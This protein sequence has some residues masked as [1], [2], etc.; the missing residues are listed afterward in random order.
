MS[1]DLPNANDT[2][3]NK[4]HL[5]TVLPEST[6][7]ELLARASAEPASPWFSGHFPGEPILP[8]IAQIQMVLETIQQ[9]EKRDVCIAGL[10]RVRFRQV[11]QP[12]DEIAIRVLPRENEAGSY[13][14][15]VQV[16][17][18]VACSGI[19]ITAAITGG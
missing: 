13:S 12:R 7:G 4:W 19:L 2:G 16:G 14:F 6:P 11:I 18:E 8:G 3:R 17:E 1:Q 10:K 9:A 5:L 15:Q